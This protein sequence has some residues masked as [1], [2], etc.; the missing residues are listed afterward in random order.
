MD[1]VGYTDELRV[2]P[3]GSVA[4]R[5]SCRCNH[6]DVQLVRLVH[7]DRHPRGPG[8]KSFS[9]DADCNGTHPG[10]FQPIINGSCMSVDRLDALSGAQEITAGFWAWP[11]LINDKAQSLIA[12]GG[13]HLGWRVCLKHGHV[14]LEIDGIEFLRSN[15][16]LSP[17]HW[18]HIAV[19]FSSLLRESFVE[20]FCSDRWP[21]F[22]SADLV[23]GPAPVSL[24]LVHSALLVGAAPGGESGPWHVDHFN[25]KIENPWLFN[26]LLDDATIVELRDPAVVPASREG[27]FGDWNFGCDFDRMEV[28][29]RSRSNATG[30]LVNLPMR[31]LTS[32]SWSG[33]HFDFRDCPG[34]YS[35]IAFH[36]E[37]VGDAGWTKSF[38]VD[39]PSDLPSGIYAIRLN[40]E[41]GED[42]VPFVVRP[43]KMASKVPIALLL[44][45]LTYLAYSN[46]QMATR[47]NIREMLKNFGGDMSNITYPSTPEDRYLSE[48]KLLSLYDKREDGSGVCYSSKLRPLLS[49]RPSYHMPLLGRSGAAHSLC[50]DLYLVD[51]LTEKGYEFDVVT[52]EDLD[53]EGRGLLEP[54]K[55]VLT[56]S[57]PE[58]WTSRMQTGLRAYL[59][60]GGRLM[61]MGGNGFYWVTSRDPETHSFIEVRRG[62]GSGAWRADPAEEH[63]STTGEKGGLWRFR[64]QSPQS[65]VGVGTTSMGSEVGRPYRRTEESKTPRWNFVFEGLEPDEAIGDFPSLVLEYGA[66]GFEIDRADPVLGTPPSTTILASARVDSGD[67]YQEVVEE[68]EAN[69]PAGGGTTNPKV[70]AD[71]VWVDYPNDGAVWSVGSIQ[72]CSCL[73]YN[74]YVNSVS[75]VTQN[76][77]ERMRS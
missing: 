11:T 54:Y 40:T 62:L 8:F 47:P 4:V 41:H 32:H 77:L 33:Q 25:G 53:D 12:A 13:Q 14:V 6:Y 20:I 45:T 52:D 29:D 34:E 58:Y 22:P 39:I 51:W 3:G 44:P 66:G 7:G 64:G 19:G 27:C 56:G 73:S 74:A 59:R 48:H 35:A 65:V 67:S 75:R 5:V 49:I 70:R 21:G 31:A 43:K 9:V 37:D 68:L 15:V 50:A 30:S 16:Q 28:R 24:S 55:V 72:W 46:E 26:R 17:H 18:Y 61:Y 42:H 63:H 60:G 76:V 38:S 1:V 23:R 57:H 36:P 71:M 2:M 69:S 10:L